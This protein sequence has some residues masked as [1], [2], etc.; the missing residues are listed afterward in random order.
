MSWT[1]IASSGRRKTPATDV[2]KA[3]IR[4]LRAVMLASKNSASSCNK[5]NVKYEL[6]RM[7]SGVIVVVVVVV[8]VGLNCGNPPGS[9]TGSVALGGNVGAAVVPV[10]HHGNDTVVV[11]GGSVVEAVGLVVAQV[12]PSDCRYPC[13]HEHLN[14]SARSS[15]CHTCWENSSD[16]PHKPW[17]HNPPPAHCTASPVRIPSA[18]H[19][20]RPSAAPTAVHPGLHRVTH[21]APGVSP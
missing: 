19:V 11:V 16:C 4:T 17:A 10:Y 7:A 3:A 5:Y 6:T 15:H 18:P 21:V 8:V 20:S 2:C 9:S 1:S 12:L 14:P 13:A